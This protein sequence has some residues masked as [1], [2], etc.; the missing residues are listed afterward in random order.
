MTR[1]SG[2]GA[3]ILDP[4]DDA[5]ELT[6]AFFEAATVRRGEEVVRRGRPPVAAPKT[7]VRIRFPVET[8]ARLRALG[9]GWPGVVVRAVEKKLG[10]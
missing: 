2:A 7:L 6:E 8:L 10:E 4:A 1:K 3:P 5:P 9:P